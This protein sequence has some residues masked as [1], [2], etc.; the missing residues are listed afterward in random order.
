MMQLNSTITNLLLLCGLFFM[1]VACSKQDEPTL[2]TAPVIQYKAVTK[3]ALAAT[4]AQAKRDS[5]IITIGFTDADGD[6]GESD[7]TRIKQL[8]ASQTWG[9]YQLRTFQLV[10]N[11]FTEIPA[12]ANSKLFFESLRSTNQPG[13]VNGTLDFSQRFLYQGNYKL[14]PVKFQVRIRDRNLNESN[15]IETDTVRVP[16]GQ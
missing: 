4:A 2:N 11:Q 1:A 13:A 7:T 8:Y 10:N 15:V 9:N 16:I 12:G 6:L 3:R 14:V 5:V